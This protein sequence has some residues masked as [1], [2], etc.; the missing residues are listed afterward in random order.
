MDFIRNSF[1]YPFSLHLICSLNGLELVLI[2][3]LQGSHCKRLFLLLVSRKVSHWA[4]W[5]STF[6]V[7]SIIPL[8]LVKFFSHSFLL[9]H[10]IYSKGHAEDVEYYIKHC[11]KFGEK[12]ETRVCLPSL[13]AHKT[14]KYLQ[15][16]FCFLFFL[17]IFF[18]LKLVI[19]TFDYSYLNGYSAP[20]AMPSIVSYTAIISNNGIYSSLT[21]SLCILITLPLYW[22]IRQIIYFPL[23]WKNE[24]K[25]LSLMDLKLLRS[26]WFFRTKW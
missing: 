16:R 2:S 21:G 19:I 3:S 7:D 12:E 25:R 20:S 8:F 11:Q 23:F 4:R 6:F 15:S 10:A 13:Y 5:I 17:L 14:T 1:I 22:S 24:K 18:S 26:L 9:I